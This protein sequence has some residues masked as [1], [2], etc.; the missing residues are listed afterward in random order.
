MTKKNICILLGAAFVL[1]LG[2]C[3]T[4][5]NSSSNSFEQTSQDSSLEGN[6]SSDS[7]PSSEK[8][9]L[10]DSSSEG[11]SSEE[12]KVE[13]SSNEESSSEA[14][15]SEQTS[16]EENTS[17]ESTIESSSASSEPTPSFTRSQ[18]EVK[19]DI[20]AT[21]IKGYSFEE[22][23]DLNGVVTGTVSFASNSYQ[24][25][26]T[27]TL[28]GKENEIFKYVGYDDEEYYNIENTRT[29]TYAKKKE[30]ANEVNNEDKAT[31]ITLTDASSD[32]AS[33]S[34][35]N[36]T[37][38][39]ED[40]FSADV[41]PLFTEEENNTFKATTVD[42]FS[43][44]VTM[45]G[46]KEGVSRSIE[47]LFN[48]D[49]ELTYGKLVATETV[50]SGGEGWGDDD[51][52]AS[53]SSVSVTTK[54]ATF[55][56]GEKVNA[57]LIDTSAY[58]ITDITDFSVSSYMDVKE[59]SGKA[60]VGETIKAPRIDAFTPSTA[61]NASD[62]E[63]VSSSNTDVIAY[64]SFCYKALKAGT[65]VLT[66]S[67]ARRSVTKTIT[68]TVEV[69][70]LSLITIHLPA[71][72][73]EVG[74][75]M[76]GTITCSPS[77]S[78]EEIEAVSLNEEVATVTLVDRENLTIN[79]IKAGKA[80]IEVH[81]KKNPTVKTNVEITVE[82]GTVDASWVIGEWNATA[83][84][85][86]VKLVFNSDKTGSATQ[87]FTEGDAEGMTNT[88]DFSWELDANGNLVFSSWS[89]GVNQDFQQPSS[90]KNDAS[91]LSITIVFVYCDWTADDSEGSVHRETGNISLTKKAEVTDEL[92]PANNYFG[93]TNKDFTV[94]LN[95]NAD[96][97]A[98]FICENKTYQIN[99][100]TEAVK[101]NTN[102]IRFH[103]SFITTPTNGETFIDSAVIDEGCYG[104]I[105]HIRGKYGMISIGYKSNSLGTNRF[106]LFI[107]K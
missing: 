104:T 100:S 51:L 27:Q 103:F 22:T 83:R 57:P 2:G 8:S 93:T 82:G 96:H 13:S 66:I 98:T 84:A 24:L 54:E 14:T 67:D 79:G 56:L 95:L 97:T 1:T 28:L 90:V 55:L 71:R 43:Y 92:W 42:A 94:T 63:I 40:W 52:F 19:A 37:L 65:S 81:S 25:S 69:P 20:L 105:N 15:S 45:S 64:E 30:I 88:A 29:A 77:E 5:D 7:I 41:L 62:F 59:N 76:N 53:T 87:T 102:M 86:T 39:G 49:H 12:S 6:S 78:N 70:P 34:S 31:K 101:G 35:N 9:S 10:P 11:S 4:N 23:S 61:L 107:Q 80:I 38:Y 50:S 106:T 32:V 47:L 73:L 72:S 33:A 68:M 17:S 16:N 46:T 75:A 85:Y 44:K 48:E 18:S 36:K 89:T 74:E 58:F 91:T 3:T 60:L 26:G 21:N 99:W